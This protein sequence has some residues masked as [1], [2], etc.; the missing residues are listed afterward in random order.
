MRMD[1]VWRLVGMVALFMVAVTVI[2]THAICHGGKPHLYQRI[3]AK[4]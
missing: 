1:A 2:A 4:R 3:E